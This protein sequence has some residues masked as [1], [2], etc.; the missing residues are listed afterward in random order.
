MRNPPG[1]AHRKHRVLLETLSMTD[2]GY[3][4]LCKNI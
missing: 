2:N 3:V 1:R 4:V